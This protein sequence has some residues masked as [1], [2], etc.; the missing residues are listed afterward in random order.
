MR[1]LIWNLLLLNKLKF[2]QLFLR[3][4]KIKIYKKY[5]FFSSFL[6]GNCIHMHG[7]WQDSSSYSFF[8]DPNQDPIRIMNIDNQ[9]NLINKNFKEIS[10]KKRYY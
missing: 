2:P 8:F 10:Y 5:Q 6:T 4:T 3:S 1:K 9:P 7:S